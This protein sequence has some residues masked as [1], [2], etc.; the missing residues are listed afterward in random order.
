MSK[1]FW[2][3]FQCSLTVAFLLQ[4]QAQLDQTGSQNLNDSWLDAVIRRD[5]IHRQN[6]CK[7]HVL[8][9]KA[10]ARICMNLASDTAS[11]TGAY[12][13]MNTPA[14]NLLSAQAC[15]HQICE[16]PLLQEP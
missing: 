3:M 16:T 15:R 1:R 5:A 2:E 14:A 4:H 6:A 10:G 13:V 7:D 12:P 11:G 9:I 8:L